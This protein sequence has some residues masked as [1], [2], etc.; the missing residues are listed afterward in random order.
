MADHRF[1]ELVLDWLEAGWNESN[2]PGDYNSQVPAFVDK[3]D[4]TSNSYEGREV[5][6]DLSQNNAII[7]GSTPD[8][9]QEPIGTEFDY[10]FDDGASIRVVGVHTNEWGHI[11]GSDEF[12]ALYREARRVLHNERVW[13]DR[14]AAGD[15]H[16][17]SM[18]I[19]DETNLSGNYADF[20]EYD[21]TAMFSGY[22][23]LP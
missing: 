19:P 4:G 13:P 11:S 5:A 22:E 15:Q 9:T 17:H 18:R 3:D 20:Y 2:Y 6:Y 23:E 12:R 7:V 10:R 1:V 8:R 14:N 21:I 16:S